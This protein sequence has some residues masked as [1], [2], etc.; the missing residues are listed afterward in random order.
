MEIG[1]CWPGNSGLSSNSIPLT[2]E[3]L[4]TWFSDIGKNFKRSSVVFF[5]R[6][7]VVTVTS[8][9]AVWTKISPFGFC[10]VSQ[11]LQYKLNNIS[12]WWTPFGR[13]KCS[14]NFS[15]HLMISWLTA[16][17]WW[18]WLKTLFSV[19]HWSYPFTPSIFFEISPFLCYFRSWLLCDVPHRFFVNNM[20]NTLC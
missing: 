14:S 7:M 1:S 4:F 16:N 3:F 9:A 19:S 5:S 15:S 2:I 17:E 18:C 11:F 13:L 6:S 12:P 20:S 8:L 10:D